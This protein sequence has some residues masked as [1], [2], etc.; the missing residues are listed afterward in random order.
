M[1]VI[2]F[3]FRLPT[4][5]LNVISFHFRLPTNTVNCTTDFQEL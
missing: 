2:S 3:H 5:K 1:N 4:N